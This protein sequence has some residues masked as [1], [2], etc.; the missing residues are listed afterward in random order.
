MRE[1]KV[2]GARGVIETTA[3]ELIVKTGDLRYAGT[4]ANVFVQVNVG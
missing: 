2:N 3:Y 1:L 4:D